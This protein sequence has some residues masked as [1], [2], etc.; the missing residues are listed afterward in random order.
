[1]YSMG[2]PRNWADLRS[3]QRKVITCGDP[4]YSSAVGLLRPLGTIHWLGGA[5]AVHGVWCVSKH[6]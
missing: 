2:A 3:K 6:H 4:S 1:M 5:Y